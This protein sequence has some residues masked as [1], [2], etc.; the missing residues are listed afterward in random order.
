MTQ[1][2]PK[3]SNAWIFLNEDEPQDAHKIGVPYDDPSSSYQRLIS[4]DVY[5]HVD[6]LFLCFA[7]IVP[8]SGGG[9]TL[10][11]GHGEH[12][13]NA[14]DPTSTNQDYMNW[15]IRDARKQN[16]AIRISMTLGYGDPSMINQIFDNGTGTAVEEAALF[17]DNLVAFLDKHGLDGLDIDWEGELVWGKFTPNGQIPGTTPANMTAFIQAVGAAF[18]AHSARK[19]WFTMGP[20]TAQNLDPVATNAYVDFLSLQ[21]YGAASKPEFTQ[22]GIDE[23]LLAYGA[24]FEPGSRAGAQTADQ[25]YAGYS[26][27]GYRVATAW[28]LNSGNFEHEQDAQ[29][30]FYKMVHAG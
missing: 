26:Q 25:A 13:E 16:P 6:I 12:P 4:K 17:A 30:A 11:I 8:A 15:I 24:H 29:V 14:P 23:N 18:R 3:M 5:N 1:P 19:L 9:Y 27:G 20:N 2:L 28:R 21:L 10:Q 7:E 22:A